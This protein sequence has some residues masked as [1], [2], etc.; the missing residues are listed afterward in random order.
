MRTLGV[1]VICLALLP[2]I[3]EA[4]QKRPLPVNP[5]LVEKVV[6]ASQE[7][8]GKTFRLELRLQNGRQVAY[9]FTP[10]DADKVANGLSNPA[11]VVG[12]KLE[13]SLVWGMQIEA[14]PEQKV[15][16]IA[17][18]T[19]DRNLD[20]LAI[21]LTAADNLVSTLQE[22]FAEV[23]AYVAKQGGQPNAKPP[24]RQEP[25]QQK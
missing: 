17:P 19:K 4:A 6:K 9:E 10:A 13:G 3:A 21:P 14:V 23:K 20:T 22:K 12:Q 2:Q 1:L 15:V 18:R 25:A 8:G 16:I 24:A 11:I 7:T 5:V